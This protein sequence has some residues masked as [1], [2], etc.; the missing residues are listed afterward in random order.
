MT[1]HVHLKRGS[2]F[3][4]SVGPAVVALAA[5]VPGA[6][7]HAGIAASPSVCGPHSTVVWLESR[8]SPGAG[9]VYYMLRLTNLS[10]GRCSLR[11]YPGVSAIDTAGRQLGS[12][13]GRNARYPVRTILLAPGKSAQFLLQLNDPG[14]FPR[15]ACRPSTAAGL[16]VYLPGVT[17]ATV[18]PVPF[19]ACSHVGAVFLHATAVTG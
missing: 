17:A 11:G 13:A 3:V 7:S 10:Q 5:F 1:L 8:G 12:A 16:R 19:G 18:V 6:S 2:R 14:F 15:S 4:L 9:S